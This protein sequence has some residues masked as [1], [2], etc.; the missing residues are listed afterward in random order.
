MKKFMRKSKNVI[1]KTITTAAAI[2]LFYS[3]MALEIEMWRPLAGIALTAGWL[4]AYCY[5]N[6]ERFGGEA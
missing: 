2:G 4:I 1:L 5:A 3:L 6:R